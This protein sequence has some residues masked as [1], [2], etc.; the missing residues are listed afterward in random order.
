MDPQFEGK[1]SYYGKH[2]GTWAL[3]L[4]TLLYS[5]LSSHWPADG[6]EWCLLLLKLTPIAVGVGVSVQGANRMVDQ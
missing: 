6:R 2:L 5:E 1:L 4:A 3:T